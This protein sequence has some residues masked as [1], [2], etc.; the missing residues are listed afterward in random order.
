[1]K[2]NK[3]GAWA[4]GAWMLLLT[5][6]SCT[7]SYE[8]TPVNMFT[9]DYL[10][11]RTDSNGV[12]ARQFLNRIYWY[13]RN[14]HNGVNGDYL[15]AASDDA[16]SVNSGDPDVYKLAVGR[17]SASST[18][19]SDMIWTDPY[20]LIR[21]VNILLN[22]ID[23]VPFNT[24]YIDAL[25]NARPLNVSM[26]AEARFLRAYFYF[27]LMKRYGGIPIIGD[28][29]YDLNENI[30]LPRST[31]EQTV[32]YIVS[33]LD[34]I[35]DDLRSL[36]LPDAAANAHVVTTQAAQ[37][38]KIRVLL[39]AASPLFNE[40]PVE[41]GNELVG[42]ATYD[43][44]RWKTAADAAR[45]FM[46][47]Y[48]TDGGPLGLDPNFKDVFTNWY[49]NTIHKEMIF[50]REND[51]NTSIETANGPLGLS[52][53]KQG[54]GR[55]NPTQNLVDA[56]LMK[57]GYFINE[58]GSA[59]EYDPQH[60]Y[61]NRDPRLE[62]TIIHNGTNWLNNTMQ[63]WQGGANN[64]LG[65]SYSLTSYYMRK[66]MGNFESGS[67]Y[68][69]TLHNWVMFRYA[70]ILLN[71]AEAE[72]E[73]LSSPSQDVYDAIIA[74]RKRAGIEAGNDNLYGLRDDMSQAD[75]RKVIQ[76][77]RRIELAFEEHRYWDIRRWRL[78][79]MIYAQPVKGM[80]ITTSLTGT[81][82]IPQDVLT[83]DWDNKRYLYPIPY[84][85]VIKNK[86]MVQNPNW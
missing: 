77:E 24:T 36:P 81:T 79:E 31:F 84:S 58:E 1:M 70:E 17:Y 83:V 6:V 52:G 73:Y 76:N 66:F 71:F 49:D 50:F 5:A 56:F 22:G 82:Y 46:N 35:K 85:E 13:M 3:Y 27:E 54:N 72:N 25:G 28:K 65:S 44:E 23:V 45:S 80:F 4:I 8:G 20:G 67:E 11:S 86:N 40:K 38:L 34:A 74:L 39:Y 42:Y 30:E 14:G 29:V 64:P 55:T 62:Y 12:V 33:E 57:D 69:A 75:M 18:I 16:L 15:D 51:S 53:A 26:K 19:P 2:Q 21:R 9:E 78:A 60:P 32:K 59:Y 63:T 48:G 37:A 7:D 47:A 43:R 68:Q 61:D 10:F 41:S